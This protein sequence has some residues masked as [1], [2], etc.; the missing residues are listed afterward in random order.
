MTVP[1]IQP[2]ISSVAPVDSG[3]ELDG[4]LLSLIAGGEAGAPAEPEPIG[5]TGRLRAAHY[6]QFLDALGVAMYTTDA[7]GRIT[8]F[9]AAA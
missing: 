6:R 7:A 4:H 5:G 1:A 2:Q 9:N 3:F 8:F